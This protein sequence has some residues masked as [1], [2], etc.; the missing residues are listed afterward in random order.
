MTLIALPSWYIALGYPVIIAIIWYIQRYYLRSSRQLRLL[1]LETRSPLYSHFMETISGLAT[2]RAFAWEQ[3]SK[4][5]G[6]KLLNES[7]IPYYLLVLIQHWLSLVLDLTCAAMAVLIVGLA[8]AT[9]HSASLGFTAVALVSLI[10]FSDN[11]KVL[12]SFWTKTET[13]LGALVRIRSFTTEVESEA[14]GN[15]SSPDLSPDW[16]G[17]GN[18]EIRDMAVAYKRCVFYHPYSNATFATET[19]SFIQLPAYCSSWDFSICSGR[20]KASNLW[21][22]WQ[23]GT[24]TNSH[25]HQP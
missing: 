23:V 24:L 9:R 8:A 7:Q 15:E 20:N 19:N 16:P 14:T 3:E 4:N 10:S 18:M 11:L 12:V 13:S 5:T 25:P 2:I 6:S 1:D 21:P 22:E 17:N